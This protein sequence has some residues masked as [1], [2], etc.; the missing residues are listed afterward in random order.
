VWLSY[1]CQGATTRA[2]KGSAAEA[3]PPKK[4]RD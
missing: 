2:K 4:G 1:K 3:T